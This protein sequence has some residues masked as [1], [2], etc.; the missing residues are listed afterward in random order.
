MIARS[1]RLALASQGPVLRSWTPALVV[2]AAT[3]AG[4]LAAE[5]PT[6]QGPDAGVVAPILD[7]GF[8]YEDSGVHGPVAGPPLD[9]ATSSIGMRGVETVIPLRRGGLV[10]GTSTRALLVPA[11]GAAAL[12][13]GGTIGT[14]NG[15]ATLEWGGVV[16]AGS[17]GMFI[18]EGGRL[19]ASPLEG[20]VPGAQVVQ[21]L[22]TPGPQGPYDLWI[23]ARS[24]L[25]LWRA[26][27]SF[28]IRPTGLPTTSPRVAF[29]APLDGR[30]ALWVA[31]GGAVYALVGEAGALQA[32]QVLADAPADGLAVD[33]EGT[34]WLATG[35]TLRSRGWDGRWYDHPLTRG[36]RAIAAHPDALDL[37]VWA[38]DGLWHH[39][40]GEFRPVRGAPTPESLSVA[41]DGSALIRA[42]GA[43]VRVVAGHPVELRG[44]APE[45]LLAATTEIEIRP[46]E[47][48]AVRAVE[49]TLDGAAVTLPSSAP[50]LLTLDPATLE[51]GSHVLAVVVSHDDGAP[52]ARAE[53]R[54]SVFRV[55]PPTWSGDIHPL[56]DQHCAVCHGV[57]GSARRLNTSETWRT[58]IQRVLDAVDPEDMGPP[59]MP[60]PPN[61]P[62]SVREI[63]LIR[64]WRAAGFLE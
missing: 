50:W 56:F 43:L 55:R 5:S 1:M 39:R 23:A 15:A 51:D 17:S 13:L 48:S 24:G 60:L 32:Q 45:S 61:P 7:G 20:V 3:L 44:L 26:G 34:L 58:E 54:F 57:A 16:L 53:L 19:Q 10:V 49:A 40:G 33:F 18:L 25:T 64:G 47:P 21:L 38:E 2:I 42:G 46:S 8:I 6:N 14:L 36:V 41:S 28:A 62:L 59:T 35:G 9:V 12:D 11:P 52:D 31:S 4:C 22:S 30:P 63:G 37:W 27:R 29:G